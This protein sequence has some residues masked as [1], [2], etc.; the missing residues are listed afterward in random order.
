LRTGWR[1]WVAGLGGGPGWI[2]CMGIAR[3]DIIHHLS[4]WLQPPVMCIW[5]CEWSRAEEGGPSL[6]RLSHTVI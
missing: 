6:A 3:A 1:A 2:D 4:L 5:K